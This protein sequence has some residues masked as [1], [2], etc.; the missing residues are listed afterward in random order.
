MAGRQGGHTCEHRFAC[1]LDEF[2]PV[3]GTSQVLAYDAS[4]ARSLL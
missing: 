3:H 4:N 1:A 2:A